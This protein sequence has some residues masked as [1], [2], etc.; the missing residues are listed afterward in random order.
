MQSAFS[1][2]PE[3]IAHRIR[4]ST[5][6]NRIHAAAEAAAAAFP[7]TEK[8]GTHPRVIVGA[9]GTLMT[10]AGLKIKFIDFDCTNATQ[11]SLIT[12]SDT[13]DASILNKNLGYT[14]GS[15]KDCY[16]IEKPVIVQDCNVKNLKGSI[17]YANKISWG[18]KDFRIVNCIMQL[19]NDS[20][21]FIDL[22]ET[23]GSTSL[24]KSLSI[25]KN[26]FYNIKD[27][28]SKY[29]IRYA[30]SSNAQPK[31][32]FGDNQNSATFSLKNNTFS[33]M[34]SGKDFGNNM[35]NTNTLIT[36]LENNIFYDTYRINK[37]LPT[38]GERT[39]KNNIIWGVTKSID[40]NDLSRTDSN[41]N[42]IATEEDPGFGMILQELDLDQTNGGVNFTPQGTKVGDP[43]WL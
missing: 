12:L 2:P 19:A 10:Q 21:T 37:A 28:S 13:P 31:K 5:Q 9:E 32:V 27:N 41:G 42:T 16:I 24:I 29:F 17:L 25:E 22:S 30:N 14:G 3:V 38:Q 33:K 26:T 23:S 39:Y 8:G 6:K 34:M 4:I 11:T 15:L 7:A 40:G 35:P 20:K 36:I 43:R 1:F 18:L